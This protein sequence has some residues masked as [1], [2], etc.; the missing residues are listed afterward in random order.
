[1]H[2]IRTKAGSLDKWHDCTRWA[3]L[4]Q[5]PYRKFE[6]ENTD[7][8]P[9]DDDSE[10]FNPLLPPANPFMPIEVPDDEET[11]IDVPVGVPPVIPRVIKE[12]GD[13]PSEFPRVVPP[14]IPPEKIP[15]RVPQ[16][17]E[18]T[19]VP[20]EFPEPLAAF[21]LKIPML[22]EPTGSRTVATGGTTSLEPTGQYPDFWN[23]PPRGPQLPPLPVLERTKAGEPLRQGRQLV[24]ASSGGL[25]ISETL[26]SWVL[27]QYSS[28][29]SGTRGPEAYAK[30]TMSKRSSS[31]WS[32]LIA[33]LAGSL[34]LAGA[35]ALAGNSFRGGGGG[36]LLQNWS[37]VI[38]GL[39]GREAIVAPT[40]TGRSTGAI[41][42]QA[43]EDALI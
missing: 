14:V 31:D 39:A 41:D 33:I 2:V 35:A 34:S 25:A 15:G 37:Q 10:P 21:E 18:E 13:T 23:A 22:G 29:L 9:P 27:R 28:A 24:T 42:Q 30:H 1:M 20:G 38:N 19:E 40:A 36:G 5:C 8:E 6:R 12:I 11:P 16:E 3:W 32:R 17:P 43:V 7:D 26:S 4:G